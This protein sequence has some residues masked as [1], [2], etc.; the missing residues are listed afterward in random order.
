MADYAEI[1]LALEERLA[2]VRTRIQALS[3]DLRRADGP[4]SADFEEQATAVENDEV[5]GALDV[6][7]RRDYI[8]ITAVLNRMAAGSYGFC[9]RCGERIPVA[10]L[11]AMP[12]ARQCV[13]CAA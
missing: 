6:A 12:S 5:L 4:I 13:A 3:H 10:R 7:S 1:K 8:E 9:E 11:R 2:V